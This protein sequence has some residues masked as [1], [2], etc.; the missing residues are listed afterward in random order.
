MDVNILWKTFLE[1]IKEQISSLSYETWFM[2]GKLKGNYHYIEIKDDYSDLEEKLNYYSE[3]TKEA[4]D[5][6]NNAH[7]F[8]SEF[9]DPNNRI[10][11]F[12]KIF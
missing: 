3:H 1:K 9:R 12:A 7:T 5:I 8:I 2:E 6:I 4:L 11:G 10:V